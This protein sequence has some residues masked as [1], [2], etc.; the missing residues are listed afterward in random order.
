M[1]E[2]MTEIRCADA[3]MPGGHYVQAMLHRDTLYV[4]GQLGV[5]RDTPDPAAVPIAEQVS[6]ALANIAAIGRVVGA[7]IDDIVRCTVYVT[8]VAHWDEVNRAYAAF[9]GAHR[10]ARSIVPCGPLHFGALVEI[11]AVIAASA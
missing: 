4:S 2:K 6:F 9:F 3:P 11:E 8:D 10:P 7:G 1:T 5:T